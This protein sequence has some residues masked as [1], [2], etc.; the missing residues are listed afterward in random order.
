MKRIWILGI[1]IVLLLTV[2]CE[3]PFGKKEEV[4]VEEVLVNEENQV[5][6][7]ENETVQEKEEMP[8]QLFFVFD[9]YSGISPEIYM[10]KDILL[11]ETT[12]PEYVFDQLLMQKDFGGY[13]SPIPSGSKLLE[14]K[15]E[16]GR[17]TINFSKEFIENMPKDLTKAKLRITAIV[18]TM[19]YLEQV[20][21]VQILVE[22][23]VQEECNGFPM[24][25]PFLY[26]EDFYFDK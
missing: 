23:N 22:G 12:L 2:G 18:N 19:T 25:D 7:A 21:S 3:N 6:E 26:Q 16:D 9:D 17:L 10:V 5:V 8:Y 24:K 11:K 14:M 15:L 4:S 1:A 13:L 20:D